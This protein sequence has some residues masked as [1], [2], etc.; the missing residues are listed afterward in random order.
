MN[1]ALLEYLI[2]TDARAA[3]L[4]R[5]AAITARTAPREQVALSDRILE[6]WLRRST[7]RL[8]RLRA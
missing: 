8:V 3:R 2:E 6:W 7:W 4:A 5:E 1:D